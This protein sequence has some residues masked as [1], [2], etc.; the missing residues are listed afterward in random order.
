MAF[1]IWSGGN[2][3]PWVE[4]LLRMTVD[5]I[6]GLKRPQAQIDELFRETTEQIK[7]YTNPSRRTRGTNAKLTDKEYRT[8]TDKIVESIQGKAYERVAEIKHKARQEPSRKVKIANWFAGMSETKEGNDYLLTSAALRT[9][10]LI[11][12]IALGNKAIDDMF[13]KDPI[14]VD[15]NTNK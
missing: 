3:M 1:R 6:P 15:I 12:G 2:A 5:R 9:G 8:R 10:G 7:Y 14:Q 11:G 4:D 13:G